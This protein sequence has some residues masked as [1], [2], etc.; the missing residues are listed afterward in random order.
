[1]PIDKA[2]KATDKQIEAM[3]RH[4][5]KIYRAEQKRLTK[6]LTTFQE[7]IA[8]QSEKL[9]DE[10]NKAETIKDRQ[11]AKMQ[12][13][14]FYRRVVNSREFKKLSKSAA[15]SLYNVNVKLS[16]ETNSHT[17][18]IY[19]L[20]Y[21]YIGEDIDKGIEQYSFKP[22]SVEDVE[23]YGEI[24]TQTIDKQKD[25]EWNEKNIAKSVMAGAALYLAADHIFNRTAKTVVNKNVASAK[26]QSSGMLS[27]AENKGRF[28]S[29]A[30]AN[31]EG[32]KVGK[33][34]KATLDN[35]T[36]DSHADLDGVTIPIDE[37]FDN[38]LLKPRD[39]N[40]ALSEICNCRCR[41]GYDVGQSKGAT[42]SYRSGD[43]TGSFKKSSSFTGTTSE[44]ISNMTYREW[45]QWRQT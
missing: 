39:P 16:K 28:D 14:M 32:F 4:I 2:H 43:V 34:W 5:D 26:M 23:K 20:N 18:E 17:A 3:E 31:D 25:T 12:Y 30:R 45:M 9:L 44:T 29:I 15:D 42:R 33:T 22:V 41:L 13:M 24:T 37:L 21:N 10:I 40:G 7:S 35:R 19:A 8:E 1:M 11:A 36:R 27:D 6:R 38:G